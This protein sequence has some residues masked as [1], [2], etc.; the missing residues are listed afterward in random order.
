MKVRKGK[1]FIVPLLQLPPEVKPLKMIWVPS[2]TFLMGGGPGEFQDDPQFEVTFGRGFWLSKYPITQAQWEAVMGDN[3]SH[4]EH[5][6]LDCPVD[7]INWYQAVEFCKSVNAVYTTND[8]ENYE[9][10]LPFEAQWEYACCGGNKTTLYS[11][12]SQNNLNAIAWH[13][14]NSN[15]RT[16]S[17]GEKAA[18]TLGLHDMLGN[19]FE[20][21]WDSPSEYPD[22]SVTDW[23]GE[24]DGTVR[25]I[26]GGSWGTTPT[27]DI[28][29]C[30]CRG[31]VEPSASRAWFGFRLCYR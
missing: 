6:C 3:P 9:F 15:K 8:D 12:E 22:H 20:W 18:N 23:V 13:K 29:R 21:C 31:W 11:R 4:F 10:G 19:V 25:C 16:H 14:G 17:V 30:N 2:G 28:F 24:G 7:N 1:T 26:R 5:H 27:D